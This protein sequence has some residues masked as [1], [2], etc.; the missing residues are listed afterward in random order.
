MS[1]PKIKNQPLDRKKTYV[2]FGTPLRENYLKTRP[3][4]RCME[5]KYFPDFTK[6]DPLRDLRTIFDPFR[7]W[8][9]FL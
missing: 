6:K 9:G 2:I 1:E 8:M 7:E 5:K 4:Q 3:L